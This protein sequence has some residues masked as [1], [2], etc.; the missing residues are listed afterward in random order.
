MKSPKPKALTRC[1]QLKEGGQKEV[2]L[3]NHG[4]DETLNAVGRGRKRK[5]EEY[6]TQSWPKGQPHLH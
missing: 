1:G 4:R 2:R 6:Q 5:V 3:V